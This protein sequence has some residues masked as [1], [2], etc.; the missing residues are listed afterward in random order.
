[1]PTFL[2]IAFPM[3]IEILLYNSLLKYGPGNLGFHLEV[4]E[5]T[6]PADIVQQLAIPV[7]EIFAAWRNGRN[8]M[9]SFGGVVDDNKSLE[10]GERLAF[11]G[12]VPFSR[13][14]GAP[15]C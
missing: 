6:V 3:K 1:M 13:A 8:I 11:S 10:D 7:D 14:Y 15:V 4:S 9:D 2:L 12:P 5:G